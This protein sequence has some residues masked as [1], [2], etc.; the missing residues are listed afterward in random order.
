MTGFI[1]DCMFNIFSTVLVGQ[2]AIFSVLGDTW[3]PQRMR[4]YA[5]VCVRQWKTSQLVKWQYRKFPDTQLW[6]EWMNTEAV[7]IH[8][9]TYWGVLNRNCSSPQH[10]CCP[11]FIDTKEKQNHVWLENKQQNTYYVFHK[12]PYNIYSYSTAVFQHFF[13][14]KVQQR[15]RKRNIAQEQRGRERK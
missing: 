4:G 5:H 1:K 8:E 12:H 10:V 2:I 7:L 13:L 3:P 9:H 11:V 6:H 15:T 14:N